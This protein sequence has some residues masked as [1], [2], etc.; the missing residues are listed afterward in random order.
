MLTS[1]DK[2]KR[3]HWRIR[4]VVFGTSQ[5]PRLSV[6]RSLKHLYVQVI[7]DETQ[8]TLFSFSTNTKPFREKVSKGGT[9]SAASQ[10]GEWVAK[11]AK[12]KGV[13]AVVFD[14]GGYLYHGRIKALAEACRK[15]GLLF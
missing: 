11:E 14:R 7:D 12:A 8:K 10:L 1:E 3:R 2:R 13:T 9:V 4:K 6:Y 15:G 5:R